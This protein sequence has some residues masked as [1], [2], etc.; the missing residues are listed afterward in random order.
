M[1]RD[2]VEDEVPNLVV[3][4]EQIYQTGLIGDLRANQLRKHLLALYGPPSADSPPPDAR[5]GEEILVAFL[6]V[7][8]PPP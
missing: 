4:P 1:A 3:I 2:V 7:P 6:F 8:P 5:A